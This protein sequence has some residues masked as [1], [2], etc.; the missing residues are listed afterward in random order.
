MIWRFETIKLNLRL[1]RLVSSGRDFWCH[2]IMKAMEKPMNS[3]HLSSRFSRIPMQHLSFSTCL[4]PILWVHVPMSL[5]LHFCSGV[6]K[7]WGQ[8]WHTW[9]LYGTFAIQG[10][11]TYLLETSN[12][13]IA[14]DVDAMG[15]Q[16][17]RLWLLDLKKC[18]LHG[19]GSFMGMVP[20]VELPMGATQRTAVIQRLLRLWYG[21]T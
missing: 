13:S 1:V 3:R 14:Q 9:V 16:F 11:D 6:R 8:S 7:V 12:E 17:D 20:K 5:W 21:F 18:K 10:T 15:L 4:L 2:E 19:C